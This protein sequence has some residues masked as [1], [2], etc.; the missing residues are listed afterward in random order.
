MKEKKHGFILESTRELPELSGKL[1]QMEHEQSG[2]RL[3]W[4]ERAEENK[5]FGIAFQTQPWDD[6]G[7]FHILEHSVLCGSQ[8]YP[9]KEPF[10]ELM[11]SSLNTYLNALTFPDKTVYPVSSRN[12]QDF[13]NLMRVYM[14]AVLHPLI[15]VKPEIFYQEGWHYEFSETGEPYYKGVVFNEMKGALA[16]PDALLEGE[17]NR[18]LFP[19]TCY[20]Y[21]SGGDPAHIPELTYE[22]F[23]AAH[24]RLY[25]PSNSYIFLDGAVDIDEV[26]SILDGEFLSEYER[27]PAPPDIPLQQPVNGGR[28]VVRYELSPQEDLTGRERWAA[29]YVV[30]TFQ[31]RED[32]VAL[33]VL[34]DLLCGDNQAPL[35]RRV[36]ESGLAKDV[37]MS[38]QDG[39]LQPWVLLE[40]RDIAQGKT[41]ETASL[42]RSELERL[43]K[44]GL[45]HQRIFAT[46]DNIEFQMR[47]RCSTPQGLTFG[48]LILESWLYGGDPAAN[49]SIGGLF[50][51]LR[52]KCDAGYFE[53][54][55][56]KAL[57][58]NPHTCQVLMEPSHTVGQEKQ[59]QESARLQAAR[60]SWGEAEL[61]ALRQRQAAIETWQRTQDSPEALAS[62]PMLRLEQIPAEP[63]TLPL[64]ETSEK[65][66]AV[67]RH[68]LPTGKITYLNLYFS[69]DD[70]SP[71]QLTKASFLCTLLGSLDTAAYDMDALQK[72]QRSLFGDLQFSVEAYGERGK[73]EVCRTFLCVSASMLDEKA[74]KA[75]E[76]LAEILLHTGLDNSDKIYALLCQHRAGFAEAI[77]MS[78]HKFSIG[79]VA[80][81]CTAEGVVREHTNGITC[82]GWLKELEEHFQERFPALREELAALSARIFIRNR[83]TVSVTA[84]DRQTEG[85]ITTVLANHLPKGTWAQQDRSLIQ[86]WPCRREGMVIPVDVSFAAIGSVFPQASRGDAK[87]M[88]RTVSLAYLWNAVRVQGGAYGVGMM[89][90]GVGMLACYSYRDPSAAR[91]LT[92]YR[93]AADHLAKLG[94]ADMSPFILGAIAESDPLLALWT[95]GKTADAR[96]WRKISQDDLRR[97]RQE[98]LDTKAENLRT[99]AEP[100]RMAMNTG[101]VCVL[102]SQRQIDACAGMLDTV[103]VL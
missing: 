98:M 70:L 49:L 23:S 42:L 68:T 76:L 46:L 31:D 29:G 83:L 6:T 22:Q 19:D 87:I 37:Q 25:H 67:L 85:V 39:L 14:D 60:E 77:A 71:D 61:E 21:V 47:Q 34:A 101:A 59:T 27:I 17:M 50:D 12:R 95:K 103:I 96:Y 18:L 24:R 44:E 62:V 91:T 26:L 84:S 58:E 100:V 35:K 41:E 45:D 53:S 93:Q 4:L 1:H 38:L 80:S 69:L 74:E 64:E 99:L 86:P 72:A 43:V 79:R 89:A 20:R 9:V 56:Q 73:P 55:L 94:D 97:M 5:T 52:Q 102:G 78:G 7:V 81:C 75:A 40:A 65:G 28:S 48:F 15:H 2:A 88:A 30:G 11:K 57:L 90:D 54:L 36:L 33:R 3:V 13:I 92:C 10:V 16:S 32:M 66:L 8:R 51:S 63:E 82:Y